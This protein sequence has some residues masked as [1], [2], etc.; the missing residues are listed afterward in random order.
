M[1]GLFST[2]GV[3]DPSK[4]LP[5]SQRCLQQFRCVVRQHDWFA[6]R[7]LVRCCDGETRSLFRGPR[8]SAASRSWIALGKS[9]LSNDAT[10]KRQTHH[11]GAST[12]LVWIF[13][14]KA[15]LHPP[16]PR[17]ES[18]VLGN[19]REG[20]AALL[21]VLRLIYALWCDVSN[22]AK[23]TVTDHGPGRLHNSRNFIPFNFVQDGRIMLAT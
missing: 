5:A 16:T 12:G 10:L 1:T 11:R 9:F 22:D 23:N 8:T 18:S 2:S 4:N 14:N 7:P 17:D 15:S 20:N 19:E 6:R 13:W 3:V 21:G